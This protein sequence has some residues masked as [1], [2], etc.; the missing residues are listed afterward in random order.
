MYL[1]VIVKVTRYCISRLVQ[2]VPTR[3]EPA[4]LFSAGVAGGSVQ[5][6]PVPG[7]VPPGGDSG[8]ARP[9]G[10]GG[11]GKLFQW[12]LGALHL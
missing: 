10:G 4:C 11:Q 3:V 2:R 9:Q 12:L 6:E 8:P 7:C 1:T 5:G